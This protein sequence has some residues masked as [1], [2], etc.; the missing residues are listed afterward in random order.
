M[1][2]KRKKGKKKSKISVG[3]D[4]GSSSVKVVALTREGGKKLRLL[5]YGIKSIPGGESISDE[6]VVSEVVKDLLSETELEQKEVIPSLPGTSAV[7]RYIE[8]PRMT[9][10]DAREADRIFD[11]LMGVEVAPRKKFIQ[12]HAKKVKNLDI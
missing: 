7:V 4:V 1:F 12:T 8:M 2:L 9:I 3:L 10:E 6:K 5:K 11:V